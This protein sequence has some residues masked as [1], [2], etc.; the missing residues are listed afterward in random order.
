MLEV[1][2]PVNKVDALQPHP[3]TGQRLETVIET[4]T[5]MLAVAAVH[6]LVKRLPSNEIAHQLFERVLSF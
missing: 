5:A 6:L 3:P 4:S 2:V 1:W